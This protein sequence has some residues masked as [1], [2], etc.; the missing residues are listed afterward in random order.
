M[1]KRNSTKG[2]KPRII[3]TLQRTR[4]HHTPDSSGNVSLA[5]TRNVPNVL[6]TATFLPDSVVNTRVAEMCYVL[7]PLDSF[8]NPTTSTSLFWDIFVFCSDSSTTPTRRG[9]NRV[10]TLVESDLSE[11]VVSGSL[12]R[13]HHREWFRNVFLNPRPSAGA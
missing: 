12:C 8:W 4:F 9:D 7:Y 10:W 11:R 1:S 5:F 2:E 3:C 13:C 6:K